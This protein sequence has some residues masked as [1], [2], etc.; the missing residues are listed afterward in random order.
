M[1]VIYFLQYFYMIIFTITNRCSCVFS[2]S[3]NCNDCWFFKWWRK[4]A[5][6]ACEIWCSVTYSLFCILNRSNLS[7]NIWWIHILL[8]ISDSNEN[9]SKSLLSSPTY[10][11]FWINRPLS[12]K[13]YHN[14]P[15]HSNHPLL[16]FPYLNKT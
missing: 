6:A 13:D 5:E 9:S 14:I 10:F 3:I 15:L 11:K 12:I 4:K 8:H 1:R 7:D 16:Y 2:N